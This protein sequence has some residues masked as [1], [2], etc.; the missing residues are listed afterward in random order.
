[1]VEISKLPEPVRLLPLLPDSLDVRLV[2]R[3]EHVGDRLVPALLAEERP[4]IGLVVG[5]RDLLAG[6]DGDREVG[7]DQR[8]DRDGVEPQPA[9]SA[10]A[11]SW[12]S[13]T[14]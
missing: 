8:V 7:V 3:W 12:S 1:L 6:A 11:W 14:P 9:A 2:V 10:R 13:V 5:A 4:Q